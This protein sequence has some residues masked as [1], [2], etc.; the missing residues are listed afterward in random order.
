[1]RS[2]LVL[3]FLM[4]C[5]SS[6]QVS[7]MTVRQPLDLPTAGG[8]PASPFAATRGSAPAPPAET[9][10]SAQAA[11]AEGQA[12]GGVDFGQWRSAD[13]AVYGPRF[14][15][16]MRVRFPQGTQA[17]AARADLERNGFACQERSTRVLECRIAVTDNQCAKEWYVVFE[18]AR[19]EPIA[20]FDVICSTARR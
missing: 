7:G 11:P 15:D 19:R 16:Q 4:G 20:G 9:R 8:G 18:Q 17:G 13:A 2:F 14:Q 12:A 1:M 6:A 5:S 3:L 10:V